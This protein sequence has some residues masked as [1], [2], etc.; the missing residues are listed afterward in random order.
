MPAMP[1]GGSPPLSAFCMMGGV[2]EV[3]WWPSPRKGTE[4]KVVGA[5]SYH[6]PLIPRLVLLVGVIRGIEA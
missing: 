4:G 6:L 5:G 3:G 2:S 1:G